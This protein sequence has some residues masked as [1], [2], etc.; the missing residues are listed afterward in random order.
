MLVNAN[1]ENVPETVLDDWQQQ[2]LLSLKYIK[3]F[4]Q[5]HVATLGPTGTSS[6]AA[7]SYFL[8]KI[9]KSKKAN[10]S[11]FDS[12]EKA[13]KSVIN[14]STNILII[15]NAYDKID[16][17]YM[18]PELQFL[19]SFVLETPLYGVAKLPN[20]KLPKNRSLKIAT[21]HAPSS[22]I[23]WFLSSLQIEYETVFV[24]STSEAALSTKRGE[25][26]LC[27]T[28]LCAAQKYG[29]NFISRTRSIC[30]LWS[31]FSRQLT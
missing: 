20:Y 9:I 14:G 22:L 3:S 18:S 16:K 5:I 17:I 23:P 29:I 15:A 8:S 1:P 13:F 28:N 30:M 19:F 25:V 26:D 24:N 6:E 7:A 31:L 21:H 27:V 11:L 12:Y 4:Y 10:L 2:L